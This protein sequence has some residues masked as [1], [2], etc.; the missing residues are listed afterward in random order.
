[1]L[2]DSSN[3]TCILMLIAHCLLYII[4]HLY[5]YMPTK[6]YMY[7]DATKN[8]ITLPSVVR[9]KFEERTLQL[10]GLGPYHLPCT[11]FMFMV[12]SIV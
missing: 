2:A 9:L 12:T 4:L 1:M 11:I 7:E 5:I 3:K 8:A 6:A 10:Q